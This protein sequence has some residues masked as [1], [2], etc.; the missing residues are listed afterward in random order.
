MTLTPIKRIENGKNSLI[1]FLHVKFPVIITILSTSH[2]NN[3]L[4]GNRR[5]NQ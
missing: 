5:T 3:S 1:V 4:I 2:D